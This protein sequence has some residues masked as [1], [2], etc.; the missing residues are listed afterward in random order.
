MIFSIA[1]GGDA[2][3]A[4]EYFYKICR[5]QK[6]CFPRNG[7]NGIICGRQQSFCHLQS[8]S[9]QV[10]VQCLSGIL[11]DQLAQIIGVIIEGLCNCLVGQGGVIKVLVDIVQNRRDPLDTAASAIVTNQADQTKL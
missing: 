7:I 9:K 3:M 6:A 11:L 8:V 1:S 5:R 10:L 2:K 4:F